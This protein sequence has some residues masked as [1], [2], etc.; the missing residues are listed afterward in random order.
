M[1]SK[2]KARL[3]AWRTRASLKVSRLRLKMKPTIT[4]DDLVRAVNSL[5]LHLAG[6]DRREVVGGVPALRFVLRPEVELVGLERLELDGVVAE[7]LVADLVEVVGADVDRQILAPIVGHA[8]VG[9]GAAGH[10]RLDLVG[11]GAERRLERALADVALVAV[12]VGAFPVVLGQHQ[13]LADDVR[14]LAVARLVEGEGHLAV[15][16][17]LRL[18][19]VA[20]VVAL[21]VV[22]LDQLVER[23]HH[24]VGG[25][26][27]AVMPFGAFAEPVGDRGKVGGYF[28]ASASSPYSVETSSIEAVIS[29]S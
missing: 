10:D 8:L 18:D 14:Q 29:V 20:V 9:N 22:E 12:G 25:D 16:G 24:V 19:D 26:R 28:T 11:A 5:L 6:V 7:I 1:S 2:W 23:P 3:N 27:L 21:A 15:A 17:L 13:Q 4:P